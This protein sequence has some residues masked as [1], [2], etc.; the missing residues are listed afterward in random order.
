MLPTCIITGI[1]GGIGS[2]LAQQFEAAGYQIVGLDCVPRPAQLAETIDYYEVNLRSQKATV[3]FFETLATKNYQYT[4]L[5]NNAAM[6]DFHE[7]LELVST[8]DLNK[9]M[10]VNL[11]A[12]ILCSQQFLELNKPESYGRIINIASTRAQQNQPNWELYGATKG[13]LISFTQSLAVSLIS[14]PVT[15]NAISPG[16]I[17]CGDESELTRMDHSQHPSRRVGRPEDIAAAALFLCA[18]ANDFINGHN[19]VV[20]GGM[21]KVTSYE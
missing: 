18:P 7:A 16:W 3:E 17:H 21:S 13:G 1:A 6:A 9:V 10:M 8:T 4:V 5:I 2:V 19:L 11:T 15:V 20:D 14:L 12:A